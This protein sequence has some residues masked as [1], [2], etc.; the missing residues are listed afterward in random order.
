MF[1][2]VLAFLERFGNVVGRLLLSIVYFVAIAPVG[3]FFVLF[4]DSLRIKKQPASTY[5]P[6]GQIND[7]LEDA[8]RQD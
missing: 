5:E 2:P 7:T 4:G 8:R 6:W 3:I 1:Q